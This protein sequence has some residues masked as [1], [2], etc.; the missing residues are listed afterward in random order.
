MARSR[1]LA[2]ATSVVRFLLDTDRSIEYLKGRGPGFTFVRAVGVE[3][4]VISVVTYAELYEGVAFAP[5]SSADRVALAKMLSVVDV[6]PVDKPI[7]ERFG[8]IR[9]QLRRAGNLI[10]D[11]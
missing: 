10:A 5:A 6:V 9:A 3:T 11:A 1:R 7:A 4:F 2:S 8:E